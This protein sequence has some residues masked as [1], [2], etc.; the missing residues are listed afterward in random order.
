MTNLETPRLVLRPRGKKV[1]YAFGA[2]WSGQ[3][4]GVG[5]FRRANFTRILFNFCFRNQN[6]DGVN[7]F[8]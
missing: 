7:D 4:G 1:S 8:N 2:L 5:V 3:K 6:L